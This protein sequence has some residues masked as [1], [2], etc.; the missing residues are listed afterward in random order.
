MSQASDDFAAAG[1]PQLFSYFA[2]PATYKVDGSDDVSLW[3]VRMRST[4][5]REKP[6]DTHGR[7][8]AQS[9]RFMI[10]S[11]PTTATYGGVATPVKDATLV[12]GTTTWTVVGIESDGVSHILACHRMRAIEVSKPNYRSRP[13]GVRR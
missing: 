6:S 1:I 3:V 8:T 13:A 2:V 10:T 7:S 4:D 12:V 9:Q 11:D 5:D